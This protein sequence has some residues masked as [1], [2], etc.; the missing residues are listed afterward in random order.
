MGNFYRLP[1]LGARGFRSL[2]FAGLVQ[3]KF[4]SLTLHRSVDEFRPIRRKSPKKRAL[5]LERPLG[6]EPI[7]TLQNPRVHKSPA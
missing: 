5:I 7:R 2:T 4:P 6:R 1:L 3:V